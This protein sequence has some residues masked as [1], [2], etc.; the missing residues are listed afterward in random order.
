MKFKLFTFILIFTTLLSFYGCQRNSFDPDQIDYKIYSSSSASLVFNSESQ[1]GGEALQIGNPYEQGLYVNLGSTTF[2]NPDAPKS[3]TFVFDEQCVELPYHS[4]KTYRT[5]N[6]THET[7]K[8]Y[9]IVDSYVKDS[10]I[11]EFRH[12]TGQLIYYNQLNK[13]IRH[14]SGPYTVED[15]KNLAIR[16]LT[17]LYGEEMLSQYT[18]KEEPYTD[19][20]SLLHV[21]YLKYLHGYPTEDEIRLKFNKKGELVYLQAECLG[22]Y[23]H[24]DEEISKEQIEYADH[25]LRETLPSSYTLHDT[26]LLV[27]DAN[28][29]CYIKLFAVHEG[30]NGSVAGDEYF[31]NVN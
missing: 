14:Q 15:A 10:T 18:L 28:G 22:Y 12:Q 13:S 21:T 16:L 7:L 23:Q 24:L 20:S 6:G 29:K 3:K 26:S 8:T 30:V 11:M 19:G 4:S 27:V 9:S 5:A 2:Q 31:I 1:E 25:L 17:A